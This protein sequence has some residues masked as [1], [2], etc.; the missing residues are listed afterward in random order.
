MPDD[1]TIVEYG[2][3]ND[4]HEAAV[5]WRSIPFFHLLE[6][7]GSML[8][9]N[10]AQG[11]PADFPAIE[12]IRAQG[13]T[14]YLALVHRFAAVSIIGEIDGIYFSWASNTPSGLTDAQIE[15]LARLTPDLALAIKAASLART[16][17]TLVEIY[18]GRDAG[19]RVLSGR[20]ARGVAEKLGAALWF[21]D[22]E[23]F[24]RATEQA[25]PAQIIP[26]LNDYAET[27][28]S[29]VHEAGGDGLKLICDGTLAI[30]QADDP[31]R[32]CRCALQAEALAREQV[33]GLNEHCAA[34]GPPV[35]RV[36]WACTSARCSTAISAATIG[37]TSP[38][39][40]R[41]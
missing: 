39:S 19:R 14:D 3:I 5:R 32:A 8:R 11:D 2:R 25:E 21:S 38:W 37:S 29:A 27:I 26:F 40:A 15:A 22:L 30:F 7:G 1:S 34:A 31:A 23:G 33:A 41:R 36:T 24:T 4:N 6:T 13:Q 18:L 9:R 17:G 20:I 28:V 35:T 12:E 16:A 10:L